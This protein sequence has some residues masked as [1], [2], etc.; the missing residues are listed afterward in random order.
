MTL[1][2]G[3]T[4]AGLGMCGLWPDFGRTVFT[5]QHQN[6]S[7]WTDFYPDSPSGRTY[8]PIEGGTTSGQIGFVRR[9]GC[10]RTLSDCPGTGGS[11]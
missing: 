3:R 4:L 9:E 8:T 5:N 10:K 2:S 7:I 6:G 1:K 11:T